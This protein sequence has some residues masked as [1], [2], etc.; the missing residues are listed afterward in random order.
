ME[1]TKVQEWGVSDEMTSPGRARVRG[2]HLALTAASTW[3]SLK[4]RC[5]TRLHSD[6]S[7]ASPR[8]EKQSALF[9]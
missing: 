3:Q 7:I 9:W 5:A 1:E 4:H 2:R 6:D 8:E